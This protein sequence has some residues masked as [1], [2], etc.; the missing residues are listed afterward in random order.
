MFSYLVSESDV[1]KKEKIW[2]RPP[3]TLITGKFQKSLKFFYILLTYIIRPLIWSNTESLSRKYTGLYSSF[4]FHPRVN[5]SKTR[6]IRGKMNQGWD[7][8]WREHFL[9]TRTLRKVHFPLEE[10]IIVPKKVHLKN[11]LHNEYVYLSKKF[12]YE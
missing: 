1:H 3:K 6:R 9:K 10:F 4:K 2:S 12:D 11:Y 8:G 5:K 7:E